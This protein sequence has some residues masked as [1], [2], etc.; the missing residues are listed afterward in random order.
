MGKGGFIGGMES[1]LREDWRGWL[2]SRDPPIDE[3]R[4]D[5]IVVS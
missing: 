1:G 2:A 5:S 4:G 3:K